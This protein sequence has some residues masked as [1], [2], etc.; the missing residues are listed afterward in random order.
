MT[1]APAPPRP[2]LAALPPFVARLLRE[3]I[4]VALYVAYFAS[5]LY[6]YVQ[7]FPQAFAYEGYIEDFSA[8]R[9]ALS[10]PVVIG[11]VVAV[12]RTP[13][14]TSVLLHLGL[15]LV[16]V[17]MI[18]LYAGAGK[19]EGYL[20][21]GVV[22]F[23][24]MAAIV[25]FVRLRP[26]RL[27]ELSEA[28]TLRGLIGAV[29]ATIVAIG[30]LGGFRHFNLSLASVYDFRDDAAENLPGVF[31]YIIPAATKIFLPFALI[32]ALHLRAKVA[33][34]AIVVCVVLL[35]GLSSHKAILVYPLI[36]LA[37]SILLS[38]RWCTALFVGGLTVLVNVASALLAFTENPAAIF[39]SSMVVR[40]ALILPAELT[41]FYVNWFLEHPYLWWAESRLSFGAIPSPYSVKIVNLIGLEFSG[42]L[43]M[44]ANVGWIGSGYANAGPVGV[45]L[46]AVG[47]GLLLSML[48]AFAE[49][50]DRR[51]VVAANTPLIATVFLSSD[52]VTSL[53]THGIL[54]SLIVLSCLRPFGHKTGVP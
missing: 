45:L 35:F 12:Q 3:G 54:V 19:S 2:R 36:V 33:V 21:L 47:V 43:E 25:R 7:F 8:V 37:L 50:L 22:S 27:L 17:P 34:L 46:Y 5:L 15:M 32:L 9:A 53:F 20:G 26:L 6:A 10:V 38:S 30:A 28:S 24:L 16:I 11:L 13:A 51:L 31:G 52:F 18:V 14:S 49:R 44:G 48:T 42:S 29:V 1:D 23:L 40:R 39:F 4:E 41:G